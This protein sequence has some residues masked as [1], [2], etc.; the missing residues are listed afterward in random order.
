MPGI[1][2]AACGPGRRVS[3]VHLDQIGE[4]LRHQPNLRI[5]RRVSPDGRAAL[6]A[7]DLG[8]L[9]GSG[10]V[11][12]GLDGSLAVVH[13]EI[14][15][16]PAGTKAAAAVLEAYRLDPGSLGRLQ[17]SF[18][19]ALWDA[20]HGVLVLTSDRFGLRNVYYNI[21][22]GVLYF[23]PLVGALLAVSAVERR[24]DLGAVADFLTFHHVLGDR[25]LL[26]GVRALP[27]ATIATFD[28]RRLRLERYWSPRYR[29]A[30]G[31]VDGYVE[32]FGKR[33]EAAVDRALTG[34]PRPGLPVS[35]GLDSRAMLSVLGGSRRVHCFTVGGGLVPGSAEG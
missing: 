18:A 12:R 34:P 28:G 4:R 23:A 5:E 30:G 32:E 11:A 29:A 13:G 27:P 15:N 10:R 26:R 31:G 35:G 16:L 1:F 6:G 8:W 14:A 25:S 22:D 19:L 21:S 2:G 24:I 17:G 9:S 20:A 7:V 3:G 33:L